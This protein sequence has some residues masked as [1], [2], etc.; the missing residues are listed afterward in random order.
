MK[1]TSIGLVASLFACVIATGAPAVA[2]VGPPAPSGAARSPWVSAMPLAP[3][4]AGGQAGGQTSVV[5]PHY[6]YP[7]WYDPRYM[8]R[9]PLL[10]PRRVPVEKRPLSAAPILMIAGVAELG[11]GWIASFV[12]GLAKEVSG[13]SCGS[14]H[15]LPTCSHDDMDWDDLFIPVAGPFL[16]LQKSGLSGADKIAA[17]VLGGFQ[18]VGV[19]TFAIGLGVAISGGGKPSPRASSALTWRLAPSIGPSGG[20]LGLTGTF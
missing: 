7:N 20:M 12:W 9:G 15:M 19:A 11:A 16:Q 1:R 18:V 8:V 3:A 5:Y 17:G 4:Q 2:Q 13:I 14:G 10:P 6:M